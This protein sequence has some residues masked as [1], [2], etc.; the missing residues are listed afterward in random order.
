A[1]EKVPEVLSAIVAGKGSPKPQDESRATFC[2]KISKADGQIVWSEPA[3]LIARKIRAYAG[4]P[5]TWTTWNGKILK[6]IEGMAV[7]GAHPAGQAVNVDGKILI[8]SGKGSL[9]LLT[10]QLEGKKALPIT[11]FLKGYPKF[12]GSDFL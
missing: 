5:G 12:I 6:I 9:E 3:D 11:E 7:A 1:A 8:G 2:K 10:V 4:W